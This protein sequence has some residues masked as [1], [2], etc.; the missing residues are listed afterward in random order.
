MPTVW[1]ASA[2]LVIMGPTTVHKVLS[3]EFVLGIPYVNRPD[4]LEGAVRS[5]QELCLHALII[6]NS[7]SGLTSTSWPVPIFRPPVPLSFS[8]TMNFLQLVAIERSCEVLFSMHNDAAAGSG[9][10]CIRRPK[11]APLGAITAL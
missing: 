3:M 2:T 7:D 6:D 9:T 11:I 5:V 8:Q 10:A 4:L 1:S